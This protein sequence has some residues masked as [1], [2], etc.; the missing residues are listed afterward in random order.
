MINKLTIII[1][2]YNRAN[3]LADCL[4]SLVN[5][6]ADKGQY[7]VLIINNNSTDSTQQIADE[8]ARNQ[9]NFKVFIEYNQGLSNARNRGISEATTEWIAYLDDD[10]KAKEDFVEQALYTINNYPFDF[11]GGMFYPWYRDTK[12]PKWVSDEFGKCAINMKVISSIND[13]ITGCICFYRK[14]VL[15]EINGFPQNLGMSGDK[16]AYGEETYVQIKLIELGYKVGFSPFVIIYHLVPKYKLTL[17]WQVKSAY[18]NGRDSFNIFQ[19]S[20]KITFLRFS[21][22]LM[23][24]FLK[25]IIKA[26]KLLIYGKDYFLQNFILDSI[27]PSARY[28]GYFIATRNKLY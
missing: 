16:I 24:T 11:F 6:H 9:E 2:T 10:A 15:E 28:I 1:C 17:S 27:K 21:F 14:D 18:A 7:E 22:G 26:L 8:Y 23:K 3:I 4:V 5:Q 12:K 25:S 20:K 13:F 19:E